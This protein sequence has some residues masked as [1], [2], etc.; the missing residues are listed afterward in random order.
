[1]ERTRIRYYSNTPT[2]HYPK[3]NHVENFKNPVYCQFRRV[4]VLKFRGLKNDFKLIKTSRHLRN[5][6]P[7]GVYMMLF[8]IHLSPG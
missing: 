1:M 4:R 3:I 2:F 5:K 8:H 6:A 7:G